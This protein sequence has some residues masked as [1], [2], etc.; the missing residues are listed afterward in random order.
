MEFCTVTVLKVLGGCKFEILRETIREVVQSATENS[1]SGIGHC[2]ELGCILYVLG[3]G[4]IIVPLA[5]LLCF[6]FNTLEFRIVFS[7]II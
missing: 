2:S 1:E 6:C 3:I 7:F 4:T 5:S